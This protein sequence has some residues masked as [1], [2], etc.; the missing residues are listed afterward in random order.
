MKYYFLFLALCI[1]SCSNNK[2]K[3]ENE[4]NDI[5]ESPK[6]SSWEIGQYKNEYGEYTNDHFV[7]QTFN[8][9]I[10][11]K[12]SNGSSP[13]NAII[14]ISKNQYNLFK[15]V[16]IDLTDGQGYPLPGS[17]DSESKMKLKNEKGKELELN[18]W[19][20]DGSYTLSNDDG[21]FLFLKE[22]G[23][24]RV[25]GHILTVGGQSATFDFNVP[26]SFG[27]QEIMDSVYKIENI[28]TIVAQRKY[29]VDDSIQTETW[30]KRDRKYRK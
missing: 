23:A 28:D 14:M 9:S 25:V 1:V 6:L 3:N 13:L 20:T 19:G 12:T 18:F 8:G 22:G 27:L 15:F 10:R 26:N 21:L 4:I 2:S 17:V 30:K 5:L 16:K 29:F 11:W 24:Y 7:Y